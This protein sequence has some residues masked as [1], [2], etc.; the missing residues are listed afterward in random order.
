LNNHLAVFIAR[1][2]FQINFNKLVKKIR[3]EHMYW[4]Y[5]IIAPIEDEKKC[6]FLVSSVFREDSLEW[7]QCVVDFT[8]PDTVKINYLSEYLKNNQLIHLDELNINK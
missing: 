7:F 5:W 4:N 2:D 6:M 3:K 1:N 8:P